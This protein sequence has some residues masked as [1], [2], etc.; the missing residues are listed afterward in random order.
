MCW[1]KRSFSCPDSDLGWLSSTYSVFLSIMKSSLLCLWNTLGIQFASPCV[2]DNW[3]C[4]LEQFLYQHYIFLALSNLF[5]N[6]AVNFIWLAV[7]WY[8]SRFLQMP[9]ETFDES[10]SWQAINPPNIYVSVHRIK[11]PKPVLFFIKQA[12][13][14][15]WGFLDSQ[16]LEICPPVKG[17]W[18]QS[19]VQE[20]PMPLSN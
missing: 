18:V 11:P 4:P 10:L 12:F 1:E 8:R 14:I 7:L 19:L 2:T 5:Y 6:R 20:H 3:H 16:W 15:T 17:T 9:G 13:K